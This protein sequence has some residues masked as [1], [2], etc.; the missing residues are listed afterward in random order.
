MHRRIEFDPLVTGIRPRNEISDIRWVDYSPSTANPDRGVEAST[1]SIRQD[2]AALRRAKFSGLVTYSAKGRLGNELLALAK[3]AGFRGII[4]GVWNPKDSDELAAARNA[5]MSD[6]VLGI[7]VGNEGLMDGRY[8]LESLQEAI[9]AIRAATKK[10]VTTTETIDRYDEKLLRIVDFVFPNAHPY[11][12]NVTEPK[13]AVVWTQE[14]FQRLVNGTSQFVMLKEV[15]LPTAGDEKQPLSEEAQ[16]EYYTELA[17]TKTRFVYF[18]GFDLPWK[19]KPPVEPHWG[20][21]HSD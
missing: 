14:G 10:P 19:V 1:D 21:F 17:K 4:V 11:F 6:I 2:L 3:E 9:R 5:A 16:C 12:S 18:E 13:A 7:C 15:G 20:I 8:S